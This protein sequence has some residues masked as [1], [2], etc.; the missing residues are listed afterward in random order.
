MPLGPR[1]VNGQAI[2]RPLA[3]L[4]AVP[5]WRLN[6]SACSKH[7]GNLA[8]PPPTGGSIQIPTYIHTYIHTYVHTYIHTYIHAYMHTCIHARIHT[9]IH[10]YIHFYRNRR[11]PCF[12]ASSCKSFGGRL[13]AHR[14]MTVGVGL[15]ALWEEA[16]TS[17]FQSTVSGFYS[18]SGPVLLV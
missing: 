12:L 16:Y 3:P 11:V 17:P 4:A 1:S 7:W 15:S 18:V 8:M 10:T 6:G 5:T 2:L 9:Y 14:L 13:R